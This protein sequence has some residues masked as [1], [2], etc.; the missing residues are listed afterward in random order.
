MSLTVMMVLTLL[1]LQRKVLQLNEATA[2][3]QGLA[4]FIK[5]HLNTIKEKKN[6]KV[7]FYHIPQT[8]YEQ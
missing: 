4:S 5:L 3:R 1:L 7:F 6:E 2:A 8:Y